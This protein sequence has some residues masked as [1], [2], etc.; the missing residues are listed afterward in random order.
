M[1]LE[2]RVAIVGATTNTSRYAFLAAARFY[3]LGFDFVPI[4]IKKGDLFGKPILNLQEKPSLIG[5]HTITLYIGA[6]H[7]TEWIDYLISLKPSRIIFNPGAEN[8]DFAR[9][10]RGNG[11]EVVNGCNLVMLSTGQF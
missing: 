5:I 8:P 10:A 11:I 4:G 2:K 7:Q 3:E 6:V 9:R 1:N